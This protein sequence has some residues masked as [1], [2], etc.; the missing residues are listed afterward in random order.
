MPEQVKTEI[1]ETT[2]ANPVATRVIKTTRKEE[3]QVRTEHPQIVYQKKKAIFRTYQVIWYLLVVIE[4]LLVFRIS[5]KAL[6]ANSFSGFTSL[7]YTLSDPL[8]LPFPCLI[9]YITL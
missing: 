2:V 8:A 4:V 6:G 9:P 5:L 1:E 7:I 3:P